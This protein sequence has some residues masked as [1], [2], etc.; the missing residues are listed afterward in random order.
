MSSTIPTTNIS[1]SDIYNVYNDASATGGTKHE[2]LAV[3]VPIS[4]GDLISA[5]R[6]STDT[7]ASLTTIMDRKFNSLSIQKIL[8]NSGNKDGTK[9]HTRG[10]HGNIVA[11]LN[12]LDFKWE[13]ISDDTTADYVRNGVTY[14]F[15]SG[16]QTESSSYSYMLIENTLKEYIKIKWFRSSEA[17]YDNLYIWKSNTAD[18]FDED[19]V[20]TNDTT[21]VG[22]LQLLG[23]VTSPPSETTDSGSINN[24]ITQEFNSKY[25]VIYYYKDSS[26]NREEDTAWFSITNQSGEDL[27]VKNIDSVG[28]SGLVPKNW[29]APSSGTGENIIQNN[30]SIIL[31]STTKNKLYTPISKFS[32]SDGP[33]DLPAHDNTSSNGAIIFDAGAGNTWEIDVGSYTF[34]YASSGFSL[35]GQLKIES[36]ANASDYFSNVSVSGLANIRYG[37]RVPSSLRWTTPGHVF[38]SYNGSPSY[39]I[40]ED[41]TQA[42]NTSGSSLL[43]INKRYIKFTYDNN[44][45]GSNYA[46][47]FK[48]WLFNLQVRDSTGNADVINDYSSGDVV[49]TQVVNIKDDFMGRTKNYD[50]SMQIVEYTGSAY[51]TAIEKKSLLGS[52]NLGIGLKIPG[53]VYGLTD[54][55]I[56][57]FD[58]D[59]TE[60]ITGVSAASGVTETNFSVTPP[61]GSRAYK[62]RIRVKGNT[63]YDSVKIWNKPSDNDF[64]W[65]WNMPVI[66]ITSTSVEL[67]GTTGSRTIRINVSCQHRFDISKV[68]VE[69]VLTNAIMVGNITVLDGSKNAIFDIKADVPTPPEVITQVILNIPKADIYELDSG[70]RYTSYA[71][72]TPF[73]FGYEPDITGP[74]LNVISFTS[75]NSNTSVA[76]VGDIITL[77]VASNE[78]LN[79]STGVGVVKFS[80]SSNPPVEEEAQAISYTNANQTLNATYTIESTVQPGPISIS[81][82]TAQDVANNQSTLEA[83]DSILLYGNFNFADTTAQYEKGYNFTPTVPTGRDSNGDFLTVTG[84]S[85]SF[86]VWSDLTHNTTTSLTYTGT[87]PAGQT[88]QSILT[89][90]TEDTVGP[91]VVISYD[92]T[93]NLGN[94]TITFTFTELPIGFERRDITIS[95]EPRGLVAN[96]TDLTTSGLVRTALFSPSALGIYTLSIAANTLTDVLENLNVA[97]NNLEINLDTILPIII[98]KETREETTLPIYEWYKYS[99]SVSFYTWQELEEAEFPAGSIIKSIAFKMTSR[100]DIGGSR[101]RPIQIYIRNDTTIPTSSLYNRGDLIFDGDWVLPAGMNN[102]WKEIPC[103]FTTDPGQGI[104]ITCYDSTGSYTSNG[105]YSSAE[106]S[107]SPNSRNYYSDSTNPGIRDVNLSQMSVRMNLKIVI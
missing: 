89:V 3:R 50:P 42:F 65:Y 21:V 106:C 24:G 6:P 98:G 36:K 96:I 35:F 51:T 49:T 87:D 59:G 12:R 99:L 79:T 91:T 84:P 78:A 34:P 54:S 103:D 74:V 68:L 52:G 100:Y 48:G 72:I 18:E 70:Y 5:T 101:K 82:I 37:Q 40:F 88:K 1:F 92:G 19:D 77:L 30:G 97:S 22:W 60:T 85:E 67:S 25:V 15:K 95:T 26:L 41:G 53:G 38:P 20:L 27:N 86:P 46:G 2:D 63:F 66:T 11:D 47:T 8:A 16:N 45:D 83:T 44:V 61:T 73:T 57:I 7:M 17:K 29:T 33:N 10:I 13:E 80:D 32:F 9:P 55:D 64:C 76:K 43:W 90:T 56:T 71:D 4:M 39:Y 23:D 81:K 94:K 102:E 62:L 58:S 69:N 31:D 104:L 107:S 105:K 75:N 93:N 28:D 14:Q